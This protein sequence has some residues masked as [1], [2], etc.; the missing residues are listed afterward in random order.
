MNLRAIHSH[1]PIHRFSGS[2]DPVGLQLKRVQI[3]MERYRG[4]GI[5]DIVH[6]LNEIN[7][8]EARSRLPGWISRVAIRLEP[9][10]ASGRLLQF[11]AGK[12][13]CQLCLQQICLRL[14]AGR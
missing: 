13:I 12:P 1:L 5:Q 9:R 7:R 8:G 3:L 11:R 14:I 2:E 6:E 10:C 4:A